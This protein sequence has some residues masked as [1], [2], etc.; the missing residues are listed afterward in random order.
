MAH[1]ILVVSIRRE[2]D[3]DR[4][5]GVD[6]FTVMRGLPLDL[7]QFY[8]DCRSGRALPPI[9]ATPQ[10]AACGLAALS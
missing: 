7:R 5:E 3:V 2:V 9:T 8:D 4:H 10:P 6:D 1:Y